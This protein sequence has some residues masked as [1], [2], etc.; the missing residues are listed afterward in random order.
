MY[1]FSKITIIFLVLIIFISESFQNNCVYAEENARNCLELIEP[2]D[3]NELKLLR[4]CIEKVKIAKE[5]ERA[6]QI[7]LNSYQ[8]SYNLFEKI[9]TLEKNTKENP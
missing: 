8:G 6:N 3:L 7:I 1:F 5:S 4:M 9:I 2:R